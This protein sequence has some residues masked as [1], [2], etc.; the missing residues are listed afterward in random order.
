MC[1][2]EYFGCFVV[3]MNALDLREKHVR[4]GQL[5]FILK[6]PMHTILLILN[7]LL[8]LFERDTTGRFMFLK[9]SNMA[10]CP[11]ITIQTNLTRVTVVS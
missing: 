4:F 8:E 10:S 3:S 11:I 5:L 2:V 1:C 6:C 9:F 7:I